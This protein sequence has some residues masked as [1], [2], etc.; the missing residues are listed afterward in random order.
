MMISNYNFFLIF[1]YW[2]NMV[3]KIAFLDAL[4]ALEKKETQYRCSS[5]LIS[6]RSIIGLF[7]FIVISRSN[8]RKK[9]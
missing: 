5:L 4:D 3:N 9:F 8:R 6:N 1:S 7:F 2:P